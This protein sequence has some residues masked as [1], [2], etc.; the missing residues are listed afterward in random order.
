MTE[1][2]A[3]DYTWNTKIL[4]LLTLYR[5]ISRKRY[6]IGTYYGRLTGNVCM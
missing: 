6:K 4:R 2:D 3:T 1:V 5:A